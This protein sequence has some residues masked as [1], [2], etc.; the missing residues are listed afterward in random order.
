MSRTSCSDLQSEK[1][2]TNPKSD[3][4]LNMWELAQVFNGLFGLTYP[5]ER[6]RQHLCLQSKCSTLLCSALLSRKGCPK[7]LQKWQRAQ[8]GECWGRSTEM[9]RPEKQEWEELPIQLLQPLPPNF[10]YPAAEHPGQL[11]SQ[12]ATKQY[13]RARARGKLP[14]SVT[15]LK[16]DG[17][18]T[19][20]LQRH[21][22]LCVWLHTFI[23]SVAHHSQN[24]L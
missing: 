4:Q 21:L 5:Q 8:S 16:R 1:P 11:L 12:S 17:P 24:K 9:K 20:L 13:N 10:P 7:L 18:L 19:I 22:S 14:I 15:T 2:Q 23:K 6:K 3:T